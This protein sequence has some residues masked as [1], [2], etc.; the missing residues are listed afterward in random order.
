MVVLVAEVTSQSSLAVRFLRNEL[1]LGLRVV[2]EKSAVWGEIAF[3]F[4]LWCAPLL[5]HRDFFWENENLFLSPGAHHYCLTNG[6]CHGPGSHLSRTL[7]FQCY[8]PN[9][10]PPP[11]P[12]SFH[13]ISQINHPGEE[14]AK[15]VFQEHLLFKSSNSSKVRNTIQELNS[16]S[17]FSSD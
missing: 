13:L 8:F 6:N 7:P 3:S 15:Y 16:S 17:S 5:W 1:E 10:K 4:N 11:P 2:F 14:E 9:L 12:T